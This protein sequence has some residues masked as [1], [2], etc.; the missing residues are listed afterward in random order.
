M[1]KRIDY[2]TLVEDATS[3]RE[4]AYEFAEGKISGSEYREFL[5]SYTGPYAEEAKKL[6]VNGVK[7]GRVSLRRWLSKHYGKD[8]LDDMSA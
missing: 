6:F 8:S 4:M 3:L 5:E 2:E 1:K 7:N